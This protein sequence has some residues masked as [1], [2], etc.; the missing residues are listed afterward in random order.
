MYIFAHNGHDHSKEFVG[1]L[2]DNYVTIGAVVI[3]IVAIATVLV[4][5]RVKKKI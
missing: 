5:L 3:G 4:I 2:S 1:M